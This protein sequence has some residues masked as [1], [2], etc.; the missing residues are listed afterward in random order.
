MTVVR[1]DG[2]SASR[3]RAVK[4]LFRAQGPVD[5]I[6]AAVLVTLIAFGIVMVYSASAVEATVQYK[7]PQY[8]LKR[9]VSFGAVGLLL[10]WGVSR[11]DYHAYKKLTYPIL[12]GVVFLL[13]AAVAGLG[14]SGGGATRWIAVGPVH[15][16]PAELAKMAIVIWLAYSLAKKGDGV[17]SF[18][19]GFVPHMIMA[20]FL[21]LLCLKQPDFG[22]GVVLMLLTFT[23]MFIAGA[24]VGYILMAI[25]LGG[26]A[27]AYL[28]HSKAYRWARVEAWMDMEKHRLDLAYQPFQARMSFGSGETFGMGLGKGLQ[29]LYLPEAHTD[30]VGAVVGEELGFAGIAALCLAYVV[31]VSRGVRAAVKAP[32][33]YGTYLAFGLSTLIALHVLINLAMAMSLLPTKGLTLP[34]MSYGGSSLLVNCM[35][36]G[37]LLNISRHAQQEVVE[38]PTS[39]EAEAAA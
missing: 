9:Q 39:A 4:D 14:H 3:F 11:V 24:K 15:I 7:D 21:M 20:G 38:E 29:V 8:F 6:L 10:M 33:D 12:G 17:T 32:D 23:M 31:L 2:P 34:F 5:P 1:A 16:Q 18:S 30:F 35:A 19:I 13:I 37:I 22:S 26:F 25:I 28:V 27:A 36:A